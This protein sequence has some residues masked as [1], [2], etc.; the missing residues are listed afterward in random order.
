MRCILIKT[1]EQIQ[2]CINS[3]IDVEVWI[4]GKLD[5]V[6]IIIN[7]SDESISFQDGIYL[8]E[9]CR[10]VTRSNYFRIIQ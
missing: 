8:R 9:C 7:Y 6:G 10:V 3:K 1:D 4:G 5:N 2:N